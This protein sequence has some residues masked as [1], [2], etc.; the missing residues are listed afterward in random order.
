MFGMS[1]GHGR[2]SKS[3][4]HA[5]PEDYDA[6]KYGEVNVRFVVGCGGNL[7]EAARRW[8]VT[9]DWRR[10]EG[11]DTLV[12]SPQPLFHT[13]KRFYPHFL[14]GKARTGSY[15]YIEQPGL[16]SVQTLLKQPGATIE[17]VVRHYTFISE[18]VWNILDPRE[19]GKLVSVWDVTGIGM[20]DLAGDTLALLRATMKVMQA[21]YPERTEKLFII[22]APGYRA[23]FKCRV[24][25]AFV[26]APA[27]FSSNPY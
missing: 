1:L 24:I 16:G 18:F 27:L 11:I 9:C 15:V 7:C 23:P 4:P 25:T 17:T 6:A 5:L 20:H 21:H 10:A 19:E 3:D 8:M 13:V 14:H 2:P 22:N 26:E 12:S